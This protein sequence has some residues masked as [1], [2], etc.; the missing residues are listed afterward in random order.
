MPE[1]D[2]T[3]EMMIAALNRVLGECGYDPV[4]G[5]TGA[6]RLIED[7]RSRADGIVAA[8]QQTAV[9]YTDAALD[10]AARTMLS[11]SRASTTVLAPADLTQV[12][13]GAGP[14]TAA[15]S[16]GAAWYSAVVAAGIYLP[17]PQPEAERAFDQFA[18]RLRVAAQVTPT[19]LE[20]AYEVGVE[21]VG[22]GIGQPAALP[23]TLGVLLGTL[24]GPGGDAVLPPARQVLGAFAA[25][26]AAGL[27]RQ[28]LAQQET[29]HR[30]TQRATREFQRALHDS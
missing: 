9:R 18:A 25:G 20:A 1:P 10:R 6:D 3:H 23:G 22:F 27:Q 4:P 8:A 21:V 30:A 14:D 12:L 2:P 17:T 15:V 26:Y 28:I 5:E 7:A 19:D 29:L 13:C 16:T 11:A 24:T